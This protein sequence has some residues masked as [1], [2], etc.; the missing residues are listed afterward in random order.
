M[1]MT[2]RAEQKQD[3]LNRI[4]DAGS[5]RLRVEGLAGAA[6]APVMRAAGLTHGAF[7]AHFEDKEALAEAAFRHA[8]TI[9]R[10]RWIGKSRDESWTARL[11]RL[12]RYYL[13]PKHRDD[14]ADSCAFSALGTDA[15]R[16]PEGFRR[17]YA[18]ELQKSLAAICAMPDAD[19]PEALRRDDAVLL[20][21]LC[22]GGLTLA[23]AV[24]DPELSDRILTICRNAAPSL[25]TQPGDTP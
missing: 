19:R 6:I 22:V 23:R 21:A 24:E 7:Y 25:L 20:M 3:S 13:R 4:L 17:A 2:R 10:P 8:L 12:A 15:A 16:A 1:T 5:A 11:V 14:R 18:E 9:S